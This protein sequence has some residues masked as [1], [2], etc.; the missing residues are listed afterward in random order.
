MFVFKKKLGYP[1]VYSVNFELGSFIF[2][3]AERELDDLE[4]EVDSRKRQKQ[5]MFCLNNI[6]QVLS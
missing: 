6:V 5:V 2:L 3:E 1:E 4:T